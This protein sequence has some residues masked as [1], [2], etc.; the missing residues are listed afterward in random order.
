[1][2]EYLAPPIT[3]VGT[4]KKTRHGDHGGRQPFPQRTVPPPEIAG[5]AGSGLMKTYGKPIGFSK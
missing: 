1:M 2:R 5:L 3:K 4:P